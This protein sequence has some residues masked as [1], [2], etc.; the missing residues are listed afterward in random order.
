MTD[1]SRIKLSDGPL[2]IVAFTRVTLMI[3]FTL[4]QISVVGTSV[5]A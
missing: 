5:Y 4:A 2:E 1:A 3:D